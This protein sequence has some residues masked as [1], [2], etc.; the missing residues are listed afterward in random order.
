MAQMSSC[1][2]SRTS[3]R[4]NAAVIPGWGSGNSSGGGTRGHPPLLPAAEAAAHSRAAPP[5]SARARN[6]FCKLRESSR[7]RSRAAKLSFLSKLRHA[8][9]QPALLWPIG[10]TKG[11]PIPTRTVYAVQLPI[12]AST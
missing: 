5:W 7:A 11:A 2:T 4:R 3:G 9:K 6:V 12:L 8:N 10:V 1:I